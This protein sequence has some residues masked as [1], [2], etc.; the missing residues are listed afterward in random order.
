MSQI[1]WIELH[2]QRWQSKTQLRY[3]YE[4]EIFSRIKSV[5]G[6]GQTIVEVGSGP[7]FL[8]EHIPNI[9]FTDIDIGPTVNCC[10]DASQ[11]PFK[12]ASIDSY[13]GVDVLHH[14]NH[15]GQFFNSAVKSLKPN[16]K[17]V[18]IEPWAGP[19]GYLFYRFLHHEDCQKLQQPFGPAF[20]DG[21]STMDGNA[22][23]SRQ[24]LIDEEAELSNYGLKITTKVFFGSLSYLL[25]GGFQKWSAPLWLIRSLLAIERVLPRSL[26]Q[27]IGIRMMV[28]LQKI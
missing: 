9:I 11:L 8:Q 19:C 25:T 4:Q 17:I 2:I 13:I 24:C 12:D 16:G 21:K 27:L 26:M 22:M 1:D 14:F 20:T 15:P 10:A 23:I 5:I 3:Y 18:L 6:G 28:V 7:G